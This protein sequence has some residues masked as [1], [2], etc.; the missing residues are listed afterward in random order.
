MVEVS[1]PFNEGFIGVVGNNAQ[2][3]NTIKTFPSL[4]ITKAFFTQNSSTG[5]FE[6]QGN[7]ILL[8]LRLQF[9][10]GKL[11]DIPGGLFWRKTQNG[12]LQIFGFLANQGFSVNLAT[13]GG[14]NFQITGGTASGSS[15]FGLKIIGSSFTFSDNTDIRGD[16]ASSGLIDNLNTYLSGIRVTAPAGPVSVN[17]LQT[18]STTPLITGSV[19][20]ITGETLSIQ[21]NGVS[22][23]QSTLTLSSGNWSL[24]IPQQN[25]L[26]KN[27]T[28][29]V[30]A[31]IA[32]SDGVTLSDPT[33]NEL[34]IGS[35]D[36]D[37]DGVS[38]IQEGID[39][40][41]PN[42]LCDYFTA[43]Q[44]GATSQAWKDADC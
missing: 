16:A 8:T 28:Y 34:V 38:D 36:S 32:N 29:S 42:N 3:A 27:T 41:N 1:V 13:F 40:T 10:N 30:T 43:S 23:P 25:A 21:V 22:Y 39:G 14:A 26:Q 7:D 33:S 20:L 35:C 37:G 4:G 18:C 2:D 5:F 15:N 24:Q 12:Q 11:L 19:T 6:S 44:T 17:S 31:V 9:S